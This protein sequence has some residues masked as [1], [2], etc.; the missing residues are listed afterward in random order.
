MIIKNLGMQV[1]S[2]W[3]NLRPMTKKM[4]VAV[5]ET[6]AKKRKRNFSYDIHAD[7]ELS[8]LLQALDEK[9]S[10]TDKDDST[11]NLKKINDLARICADVLEEKTESAEI[12]IQLAGRALA[13]KNYAKI[14]TLSDILI[15]R[16]KAS[17]V[18]EVIRQTESAPIRAI[19]YEA[20]VVMSVSSI[21][22]LIKDPLYFETACN[23]LQQQAIEFEN[24][25]ALLALE[26]LSASFNP[27]LSQR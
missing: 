13:K 24:E 7:W 19:A 25:E 12:F 10:G 5:M 3:K 4:L 9:T 1:E 11:N 27:N 26:H 8:Q 21:I 14:D 18:A 2:I 15:Q 6:N 20:L 23:V 17:E 16:Y 22:P